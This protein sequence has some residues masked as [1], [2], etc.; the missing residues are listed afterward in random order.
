MSLNNPDGMDYSKHAI[1]L[2]ELQ[3]NKSSLNTNRKQF[4]K[5]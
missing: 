1:D 2:D 3:T 4:D 5:C